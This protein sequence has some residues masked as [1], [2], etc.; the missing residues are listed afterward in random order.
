[1]FERLV[2]GRDL[3]LLPAEVGVADGAVFVDDEEAGALAERDHGALDIV[4]AEDF[5]I[6]IGET[7]E[8]DVVVLVVAVSVFEDVGGDGEDLGASFLE[9]G[10]PIP[11]LREMLAAERSH[12]AAQ[13]D[14]DDGLPA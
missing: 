4:L 8:G 10:E 2:Y 13:E 12:E 9:L 6:G 1:M 5:A 11:Q 3:P 14:E 7:G